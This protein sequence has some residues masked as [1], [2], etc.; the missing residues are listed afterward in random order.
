MGSSMGV[1][2]TQRDYRSQGWPHAPI[3]STRPKLPRLENRL[4]S[5][6]TL[7]A[8]AFC[9][10]R[11]P[12]RCHSRCDIIVAHPAALMVNHYPARET[13]E[14]RTPPP[15]PGRRGAAVGTRTLD[16]SLAA[17]STEQPQNVLHRF[18]NQKTRR[19]GPPSD[20]NSLQALKDR[21]KEES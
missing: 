6:K 10:P 11:L 18:R 8:G 14:K 7:A 20:Q 15:K 13:Q 5:R 1:S 16:Q 3:P 21:K 9:V 19:S 4:A 17:L 2:R 12:H